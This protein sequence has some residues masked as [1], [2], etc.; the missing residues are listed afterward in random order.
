MRS[1]ECEP[2]RSGTAAIFAIR[3]G[4]LGV[5]FSGLGRDADASLSLVGGS[6]ADADASLSLGNI[7]TTLFPEGSF[8]V[9]FP[10]LS[11]CPLPTMRCSCT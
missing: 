9:L 2:W 10:W 4:E 11:H 1:S 7:N 3:F 5:R 6:L 8:V